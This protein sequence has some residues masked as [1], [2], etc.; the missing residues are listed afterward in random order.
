MIIQPKLLQCTVQNLQFHNIEKKMTIKT[1][2]QNIDCQVIFDGVFY[3]CGYIIHLVLGN[4]AFFV[5]WILL[6][7][8]SRQMVS[9]GIFSL[10]KLA[11]SIVVSTPIGVLSAA[12]AQ[13]AFGYSQNI[14][15]VIGCTVAIVAQKFLDGEWFP[16]VFDA[17]LEKFK[18]SGR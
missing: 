1:Q 9:T 3:T 15:A 8:I 5:L 18:N 4:Y 2:T 12:A 11:H 17:I 14:C 6:I 10:K 13:D 7:L 16:K